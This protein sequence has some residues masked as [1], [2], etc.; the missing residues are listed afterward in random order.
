VAQDGVYATGSTLDAS[1]EVL[2]LTLD[3]TGEAA[4]TAGHFYTIEL[5]NATTDASANLELKGVTGTFTATQ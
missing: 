5:F 2:T 1:C 4:M 3:A